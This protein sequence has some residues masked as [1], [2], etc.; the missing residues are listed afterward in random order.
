MKYRHRTSGAEVQVRDDKKL[1]PLVWEQL[2]SPQRSAPK[3]VARKTATR[4]RATS[5][6]E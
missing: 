4:R 6:D 5:T 3:N 1:D 2:V